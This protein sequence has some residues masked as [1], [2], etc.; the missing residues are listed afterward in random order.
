M[1]K[2][3][4]YLIEDY[5]K[6]AEQ[7][8]NKFRQMA[9]KRE[10][11]YLFCI[12]H[13]KGTKN[14]IYEGLERD[15][16][17]LGVLKQIEDLYAQSERKREKMGILLDVL[18]TEEDMDSMYSSYYPQAELARRIYQEFHNRIPIYMITNTATF[19]VQ[20]DVIMGVDLSDAFIAKDALLKYELEKEIEK[21]FHH[22]EK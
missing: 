15:F 16:Y 20:S 9:E 3:N 4:I 17:E 8:I 19:A 18:L 5:M 10:N 2:M 22:Y 13:L 6:E 7:I 14:T 11:K 12:E 1:T 21:M